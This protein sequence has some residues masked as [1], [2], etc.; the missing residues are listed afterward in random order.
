[1]DKFRDE[2]DLEF[3]LRVAAFRGALQALIALIVYKKADVNKV[4]AAQDNKSVLFYALDGRNP[5]AVQILLSV[6]ADPSHTTSA[7]Q[8]ALIYAVARQRPIQ[9]IQLLL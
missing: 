7:G 4:Y 8:T 1:M 2:S 3:G 5:G 9:V 6:G